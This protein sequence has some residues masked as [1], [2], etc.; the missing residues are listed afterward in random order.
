MSEP[1]S[2]SS[3]ATSSP[4]SVSATASS[5]TSPTSGGFGL[6]DHPQRLPLTN[7]VHARPPEALH[8]PLRVTR[9]AMLTG[10]S[11][12]AVDRVHLG[13]LCAWAGAPPP[14][15]SANHYSVNLGTFHIKWERHTEFSTYTVFRSG[16]FHE[17]FHEPALAALPADWLKGLAGELLVGQH[18][19][20]LPQGT[21]E[22]S[23]EALIGLFGSDNYVGGKMLGG[24]ATAW[25]DF[26]IHGDGFGRILIADHGLGARQTGRLVQRLMEIETYRM[27]ALLALPMARAVLPR[28]GDIETQVADITARTAK[29]HGL[30]A[31]RALLDELTHLAVQIEQVA[32]ETSYRFAA[33]RAYYRLVERRI[34]EL[35]EERIEGLQTIG[36]FMDRRLAPALD[37]CE[38]VSGRREALS[39][40]LARATTL[41]R[42]RIDI[43]LEGQNADLLRSMDRRA[44]LQLRLQETVEGLSVVAISYYLIGLVS[45]GAKG[46]KAGGLPVNPDVLIALAIPLVLGVVW[47]GVRSIRQAM[48]G[49]GGH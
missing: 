16:A 38:T 44:D 40:R 24:N 49:E 12:A 1:V 45:Y 15:D 18:L 6:R 29:V 37:T 3:A 47:K 13:R 11:G 33:A 42:T 35:R 21:P 7:E 2:V 5:P 28:I 26:R 39:E 9:L 41:L 10:E 4:A 14:P 19:V 23:T 43:A 46:L 34:H 36:E 31:E 30:D 8:A 32:A 27:M 20:I 48:S 25:T 22:M 17:P